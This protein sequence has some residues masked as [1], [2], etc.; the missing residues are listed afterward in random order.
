MVNTIADAYEFSIMT[1]SMLS[2]YFQH[3]AQSVTEPSFV[4]SRGCRYSYRCT[5]FALTKIRLQYTVN[6]NAFSTSFYFLF[7]SVCP[8]ITECSI[9][10]ELLAEQKMIP[11]NC[12]CVA[13]GIQQAQHFMFVK[14]I[15]HLLDYSTLMPI[16]L[17]CDFFS[18]SFL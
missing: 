16:I 15:A 12:P 4:T 13:K 6:L 14:H 7:L 3:L 17:Q 10:F 8:A 18:F 5:E 2:C 1:V 11:I 9:S